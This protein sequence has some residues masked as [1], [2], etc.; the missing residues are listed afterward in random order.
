M[1][2]SLTLCMLCIAYCEICINECGQ[3]YFPVL[4][5]VCLTGKKNIE[6]MDG[7]PL[8]FEEISTFYEISNLKQL[9][10]NLV[11]TPLDI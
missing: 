1:D 9:L 6:W 3:Q 5:T 4:F 11:I 7:M 8:T 10:D 2:N